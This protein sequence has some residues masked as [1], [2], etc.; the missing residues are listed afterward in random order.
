MQCILSRLRFPA[1]HRFE[2]FIR[3]TKQRIVEIVAIATGIGWIGGQQVPLAMLTNDPTAEVFDTNL[4]TPA[5]RWALLNEI[6]GVGHRGT[7]CHRTAIQNAKR[8][9]SSLVEFCQSQE[10][11]NF[12]AAVI[13]SAA[14]N[15]VFSWKFAILRHVRNDR[16]F[17]G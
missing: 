11:K 5:A 6:R 8:K 16:A 13:P 2:Q 4:K 3:P 12:A 14:M 15:S 9:L 7:S 10:E 17:L 1:C